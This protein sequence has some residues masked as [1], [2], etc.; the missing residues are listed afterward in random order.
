[1]MTVETRGSAAFMTDAGTRDLLLI[2]RLA[3]GVSIERANAGLAPL[4][5]QLVKRSSRPG[6]GTTLQ[7]RPLRPPGLM[8]GPNPLPALAGLFL[9]LAGLVL[10]LACLNLASL[11]LVRVAGRRRELAVRAALGGSRSRLVRHLLTETLLIALLGAGAGMIAGTIALRALTSTATVTD[12][13]IV[14]EFPFNARVFVYALSIAGLAAAI[15]GIIPA[16]RASRG[17]LG[18]IL[19]EGGRGSTGRSQRTRTALV[20]AQ[21]GGSLALLIVAGLFVRSLRSVQHSDLGF[22]RTHVLNV[23]L[24]PGEIGYTQAQGADF[25][26][27]LLTRVRAL[28][29]VQSASLAMMVPLGDSTRDDEVTIP[30]YVPQRGEHLRASYNAV[31]PDYFKTMRIPVLGGRDFVDSDTASSLRV[32]LINQT[33][34]ERFWPGANAIG[35]TFARHGDPQHDIHIIGVV[36]NSRIEDP[37]SPYSPAVYVPIS[38]SYTSVQTLQIRTMGEP[39]VIAPDVLDLVKTMAPTAPVLSV[40]TMADAVTYGDGGFFIFNV[41][42]ELTAGLGLL[43]LT[44]AV[45]G[46]Y[47]VTAYAVG[48]RTQEIGVRLALGAQRTAILWMIARQGLATIGLGLVLGLLIAVGVG[49]LVRDFLVG[50]GPADPL[51][52]L[53]VSALLTFIALAA[54]YVPARHAMRVDPT[55]ALRH[56]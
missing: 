13:P 35:R 11:F 10:V 31:S 38:Q 42:A 14:F 17:N 32:A 24:D 26:R 18:N 27:Q 39:Q 30:G 41:G 36:R 55:T 37:Y 56:E 22:D 2:A 4:G 3:P 15:V 23:R 8:N 28:P 45:I 33:M 19:H 7:A 29:G 43:G 40:R 21:V 34:A 44:V 48:Q 5:Q 49:R 47:G 50:I 6:E 9:T 1:M 20:A 51:T 16:L 52:Y 12:L 53:S 54:C 25:Y 46:M